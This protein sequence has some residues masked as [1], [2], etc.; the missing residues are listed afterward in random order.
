MKQLKTHA[1]LHAVTCSTHHPISQA[2]WRI[3][4]TF[5]S[6]YVEELFKADPDLE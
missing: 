5:P 2:S 3:L 4:Q 6:T 1:E